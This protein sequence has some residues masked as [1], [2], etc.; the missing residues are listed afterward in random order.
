MEINMS[1]MWKPSKERVK[2]TQMFQFAKETV[3]SAEYSTLHKWSVDNKEDFWEK[4]INYFDI[5]TSGEMTPVLKEESF[6]DYPWFPN[7]KINFAENLLRHRHGQQTALQ[8]IHENGTNNKISYQELYQNVSKL[9]NYLKTVGTKSEDVVACYMPN[10]PETVISMLATSSLGGVFTSTSCDF[11]LQGV[12]DRFGQSKPKVL[13]SVNGYVYNGKYHSLLDKIK[14][15]KKSIPSIETIILVDLFG[16]EKIPLDYVNWNKIMTSI[17]E[18]EIDFVQRPF[19]AP[20]YIMYS[21]GT[22]GKPKCII[23]SQGGTL[24]QHVKELGLH[25][26]LKPEKSIFYFTTCGWMM[27]NWL[28]SSLFFGSRVVLYEGSPA[29][30]SLYEFMKKVDDEKI[31]IWGTSPK[32]LKALEDTGEKIDFDFKHLETILSTGAPLNPEQFDYVYSEIKN[33]I[34]LSSISGGTDII[35]CFFLGNPILPVYKGELQSKGLGMKMDAFSS[36]GKSLIS[37]EGELV[38]T[39]PFISQ[40]IGFLN[41]PEKDKFTKAYF[42]VFK[43]VW[44]HGDYVKITERG[45]AIIF[46]R[47]DATLNPGGVRIGTAEIYRQTEKLSYIKDSI[48]VGKKI[49][50]FIVITYKLTNF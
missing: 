22:T 43:D 24:L 14:E 46:G 28:V 27:W 33:D 18:S 1:Y 7:L 38:C 2:Q 37:Q 47:S 29:Y 10:T 35:G 44:H 16:Q 42:N 45:S 30:P 40:P 21:S 49:S 6:I 11:G 9:V 36:E 13:V 4:I 41:D 8:F 15:I 3:K 34:Q 17:P 50:F 12:V 25:C 32:F 39:A 19:S 20:Q 5:K 48:C 23:H 26:D 31:N